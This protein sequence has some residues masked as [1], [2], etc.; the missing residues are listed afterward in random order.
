[1]LAAEWAEYGIRVVDLA[2]GVVRTEMI[3]RN[4][5]AGDFDVSGLERRTPLGRLADPAEIARVAAFL[6]SDAASFVT[7]TSVIA[8]GGWTGFGGW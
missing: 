1:V 6:A 4:M 8:D 3:E 5:A 2:P 7:G